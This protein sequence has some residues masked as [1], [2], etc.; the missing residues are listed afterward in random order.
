MNNDIMNKKKFLSDYKLPCRIA[1]NLMAILIVLFVWWLIV[2]ELKYVKGTIFPSPIDVINRVFQ[3][4]KGENLYNHTILT[5]L[6]QSLFRWSAGYILAVIFGIITGLVLGSS[7][8]IYRL[9]MP[10]IYILQLIPGLAWIPIAMLLFGIGNISTI[11]MIFIMGYMPVVINTVGGIKGIPLIYVNAAKMM[12]AEKFTIYF[13]VLIPAAAL[14]I[15]NGLRIGLA[16][17]WRVLIAAEMIVG[18]GVGL[19]FI[20]IQSRWSLDFEAAFCSIIIIAG[21]GLL[22]E[23][24]FFGILENTISHKLGTINE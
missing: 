3:L 22:V 7:N 18:V 10:G 5:H 19:G 16:N 11:F 13:K 1:I 24:G 4:V 9:L 8:I 12:G 14:S 23:K 20:I 17:A 15:I 2:L 6:L 21:I